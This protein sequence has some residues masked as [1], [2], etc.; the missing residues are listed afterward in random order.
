MPAAVVLAGGTAHAAGVG[1]AFR[2]AHAAVPVLT[3]GTA[4]ALAAG[5]ADVAALGAADGCRRAA[6]GTGGVANVA[7][8]A[9]L[10]RRRA[11]GVRIRAAVDAVARTG[12]PRSAAGLAVVAGT[13]VGA[14]L[15]AGVLLA[16]GAAVLGAESVPDV[17]GTG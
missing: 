15:A 5:L 16:L 10:P 2:A 4:V 9:A 13:G 14:A 11:P 3:T 17:G 6:A 8:L 1:S 12:A 7:R